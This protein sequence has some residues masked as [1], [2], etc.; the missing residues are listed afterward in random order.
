MTS[1]NDGSVTAETRRRREKL[2]DRTLINTDRWYSHWAKYT[3]PSN[4]KIFPRRQGV[5]VLYYKEKAMKKKERF[6]PS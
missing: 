3:H 6:S 4:K 5:M 1:K 2:K